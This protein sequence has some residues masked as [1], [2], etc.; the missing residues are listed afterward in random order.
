M[1]LS[2][3]APAC[4][5]P[6]HPGMNGTASPVSLNEIRFYFTRAAVGAGAPFGLGEEFARS[7]AW[8]A[9]LGLDPARCA[10]PALR[11][12]A[13]GTSSGALTVRGGHAATRLQSRDGRTLSAI[14][15]GPVVADRLSIEAARSSDYI[16][17][18]VATD[19]PVLIAAA[20]AAAGIDA[21]LISVSWQPPEGRRIAVELTG[22][23]ARV[24]V[25][26]GTDLA[27]SGP[28]EV[29]ITLNRP[30]GVGI[31]PSHLPIPEETR[32]ADGRQRAARLGVAV[33]DAAWAEVIRFFGKCLVPA[34]ERSRSSGAGA[35]S[36]DNV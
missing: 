36:I 33:G 25:P 22:G 30:A 20:V 4:R 8:L 17:A 24:T 10:V 11:A 21:D 18:L 16:V 28:A 5:A 1:D 34:T 13:D 7:S 19:Q 15:A 27:A 23:R 12:L 3:E 35:G 29:A 2:A 9:C 14:H 26:D 6:D 31:P 32:I